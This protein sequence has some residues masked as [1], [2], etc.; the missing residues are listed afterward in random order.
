MGRGGDAV[1]EGLVGLVVWGLRGGSVSGVDFLLDSQ[2]VLGEVGAIAGWRRGCGARCGAV[3]R[4]IGVAHGEVAG[5]VEAVVHI[6]GVGE[7]VVVVPECVA[8]AHSVAI[9]KE[10]ARGTTEE[11]SMVGRGSASIGRCGLV[12][13][14]SPIAGTVGKEAVRYG[15]VIVAVECVRDVG[16]AGLRRYG[17][18]VLGS[19]LDS[20]DLAARAVEPTEDGTVVEIPVHHGLVPTATQHTPLVRGQLQHADSVCMTAIA[21]GCDALPFVVPDTLEVDAAA[22]EAAQQPEGVPVDGQAV[23]WGG[24]SLVGTRIRRSRLVVGPVA[25]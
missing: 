4:C 10:G 19:E 16:I 6:Q 5:V 13:W 8:S 20:G 18:R 12:G 7:L 2:D 22:F 1:H 11:R 24:D 3:G 15:L 23:Y 21:E 17:R 25:Q 9:A 14:A